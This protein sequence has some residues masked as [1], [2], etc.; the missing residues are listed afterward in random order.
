MTKAKTMLNW[1]PQVDLAD[2]LHI[3]CEWF[4]ATN[5]SPRASSEERE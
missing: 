4:K 5:H 2:G 3:T 1:E